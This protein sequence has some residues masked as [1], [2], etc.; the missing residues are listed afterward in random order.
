MATGGL[1]P[2]FS[3]RGITSASNL[4]IKIINRLINVQL[5]GVTIKI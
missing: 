2:T 4:T 3:A 5:G 1:A